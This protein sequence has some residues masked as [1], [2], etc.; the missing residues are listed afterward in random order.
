MGVRSA[1]HRGVRTAGA[2]CETEITAMAEWLCPVESQT[3]IQAGNGR[4]ATK[5][6]GRDNTRQ[7]ESRQERI[8]QY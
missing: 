3:G 1:W 8:M 7:T 2:K 4:R 6:A 5:R